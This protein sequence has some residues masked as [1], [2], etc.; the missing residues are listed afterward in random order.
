MSWYERASGRDVSGVDYYR[1][2]SYW[3]LAAIVEGVLNRY[4]KGVMGDQ[5]DVDI[6]VF[7]EQVEMLSTGALELLAE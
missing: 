3:R 6:S 4:L 2:F 5:E 1:A 7:K